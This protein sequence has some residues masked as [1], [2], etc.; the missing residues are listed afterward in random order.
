MTYTALS[1]DAQALALLCSYLALPSRRSAGDPK[2]LSPREWNDLA[3][4]IWAS[5]LK[6]PS[7]LLRLGEA[8]LRSDLNLEQAESNRIAQLLSRGTQLAI[9]IERLSSLGIWILTRADEAYPRRLKER[10]GWSAPPVLFGAGDTSL[11]ERGIVAVSGSR[12]IDES[13]AAFAQLLGKR[14]GRE[15]LTVVSGFARGADTTCTLAALSVGGTAIGVLADSLEKTLRNKEIRSRVANHQLV[16]LTAQ[17]PRAGFSVGAAFGRNKYVYSLALYGLVVSA[18]A[19]KGGTWAGAI[20]VLAAGWIPLFVRAGTDVPQGN[21][22]LAGEGALPFD[23]EVL[24]REEDLLHWLTHHSEGWKSANIASRNQ[25][26]SQKATKAR[27]TNG[28]TRAKRQAT[29]GE[30]VQDLFPI[31]WPH[32]RDVL[33]RT[34]TVSDIAHALC[35]REEQ[36]EDW[37]A[38]ATSA[39]YAQY[40]TDRH[41]YWLVDA[42]PDSEALAQLQLIP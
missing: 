3:K 24:R 42:V 35:L 27:A 41:E 30:R 23:D 29:N 7:A 14:C 9:E 18:S 15:H 33:S 25:K 19:D 32:L 11:L 20:E 2:P 38:K 10:L 36:L 39:G 17:H 26:V 4:K 28:S 21:Q 6:Q 40:D 22:L 34:H 8:E 16:L 5:S 37:L 13:G 1:P 12:D 31:V